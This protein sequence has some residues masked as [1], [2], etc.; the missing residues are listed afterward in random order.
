[1]VANAKSDLRARMRAARRALPPADV[2]AF[3]DAIAERVAALP[4]FVRARRVGCYMALPHEVQ[5]KEL[6]ERC[7]GAGKTVCVPAREAGGYVFAR[8]DEG[9][10]TAAGPHGIVQPAEVRPVAPGEM[11][12]VIVP[13]VAYDRAGRRLGHGGGHYDRLLSACPGVKVGVAFDVQMVETVPQDAGDVPVDVVVT[14]RAVHAVRDV[15][16]RRP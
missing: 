3:S 2:Q 10:A 12:L 11:D 9:V 7:R 1:M 8:L 16:G 5:T 13:A 6:I 14:E 15:P 4:A